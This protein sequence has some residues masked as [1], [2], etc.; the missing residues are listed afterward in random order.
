MLEMKTLYA[1]SNFFVHLSDHEGFGLPPLEA[2]G[3]GCL[4]LCR[5]SGGVRSY[6]LDDLLSRQLFARDVGVEPLFRRGQ[7][8]LESPLEMAVLRR[9]AREVFGRGLC[10]A[11]ER[12]AAIEAIRPDPSRA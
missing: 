4:P 5:D 1:R 3:G 9:R 8:L 10:S 6:M 12:A 7:E 2:M 11:G